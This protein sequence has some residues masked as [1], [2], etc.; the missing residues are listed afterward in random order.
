V[1]VLCSVEGLNCN[2]CYPRNDTAEELARVER[3]M[4]TKG[5]KERAPAPQY[6]DFETGENFYRCPV[7]SLTVESLAIVEIMNMM[8]LG[9]LP[10]GGG[11]LEQPAH[12]MSRIRSARN[13][14]ISLLK[15]KEK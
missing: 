7:S 2:E 14:K 5:C 13:M 10:T 4:V 11:I 1:A 3:L 12:L 9:F 8:E 6:G 15:H